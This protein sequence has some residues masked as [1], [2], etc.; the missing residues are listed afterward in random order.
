MTRINDFMFILFVLFPIIIAAVT[1]TSMLYY[2]LLFKLTDILFDRLTRK[3]I[4]R[5]EGVKLL[6]KKGE[7]TYED[8]RFLLDSYKSNYDIEFDKLEKKLLKLDIYKKIL[9]CRKGKEK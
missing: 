4:K 8:L 7:I 3:Y 2:E 6:Y 9:K 1:L 5:M